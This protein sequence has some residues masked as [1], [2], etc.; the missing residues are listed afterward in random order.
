MT[1]H[2]DG[3]YYRE[4][5]LEGAPHDNN[6][7]HGYNPALFINFVPPYDLRYRGVEVKDGQPHHIFDADAEA[8][9]KPKAAI[10]KA[11]SRSKK[12]KKKVKK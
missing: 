7:M 6:K 8:Q 11:I 4:H 2:P 10:K 9:P 12:K 1:H 3:I 5:I